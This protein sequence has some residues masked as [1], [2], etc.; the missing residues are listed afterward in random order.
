M[1][2]TAKRPFTIDINQLKVDKMELFTNLQRDIEEIFWVDQN[3]NC[4]AQFVDLRHI[5][6]NIAKFNALRIAFRN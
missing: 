3:L 2:K 6:N 1:L 4:I 5:N